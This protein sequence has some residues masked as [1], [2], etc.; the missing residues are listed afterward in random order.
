M[1][2]YLAKVV[3]VLTALAPLHD[4]DGKADGSYTTD[5][6]DGQLRFDTATLETTFVG[7]EKKRQN[8]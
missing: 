1:E 5:F 2:A 8:H 3:G 6:P 4:C 7:A